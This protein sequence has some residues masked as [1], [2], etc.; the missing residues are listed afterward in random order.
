M[1]KAHLSSVIEEI[2]AKKVER[3]ARYVENESPM[4]RSVIKYFPEVI[5]DIELNTSDEKMAQTLYSYK[6]KAEYRV[7]EQSDKLL[8]TQASSIEEINNEYLDITS[9]LEDFQ[10]DQ[11]VAYVIFRKM[12]IDL[13]EKKLELNKEGKFNNEDIIHDIIFPRKTDSDSINFENHNLWLIDE[14]L[15]FHTYANS[16]NRLTDFTTSSSEERPDVVIYSEI[17]KEKRARAVS[18]LEFKKPQ[19]KAFDEDPTKQLFRYVRQIRD[20]QLQISTGRSVSV[21][22]TTRFYCYAICDLTKAVH[23]YAE[24]NNYAKLQ[25]DYGYYMYNRNLNAH[26]EIIAFDKIVL[27]AKRR[28]LAFF[29]KLGI[30]I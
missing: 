26:V 4:L 14:L 9:K 8:K 25:G 7:K 28:H 3:I 2:E 12:I 18:L 6:G 30:T 13:L 16:D 10:K 23:E 24:N 17:D 11:L 15:A 1:T 27:D 19:R 21:D 5:K 20:N 22:N 29:S